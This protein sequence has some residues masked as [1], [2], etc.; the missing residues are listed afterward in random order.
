[1]TKTLV[2]YFSVTG[3][4]KIIAEKVAQKLN[5][6]I[7]EIHPAK[8]YTSDDINWQDPQSRSAIEQHDHD[9][10]VAIKNDLPDLSNYDNV[11]IG[12]PLWWT[13][14]PRVIASTIDHLDLNGKNFSS[15]ATSGISDYEHSQSLVN[16]TIK[17]NNYDVN[18]I[19]GEAFHIPMGKTTDNVSDDE[20]DKW[21]NTLNF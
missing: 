8:P 18:V 20:L 4:T 11:I 12:H 1:M 9:G 7:A 6:D 19:P 5:A 2:L 10:R 3:N 14:P 15:F 13:I 21:L 16:R 17:E